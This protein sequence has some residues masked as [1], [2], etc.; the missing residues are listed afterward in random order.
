LPVKPVATS[1]AANINTSINTI[2]IFPP[3]SSIWRWVLLIHY[4]AK[5]NPAEIKARWRAFVIF[6]VLHG[7]QG[8][9]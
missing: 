4:Y 1:P 9:A 7:S 8:P 3:A 6:A 5:D 2:F